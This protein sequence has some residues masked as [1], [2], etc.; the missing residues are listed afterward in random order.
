MNFSRRTGILVAAGLLIISALATVY[1]IF[2][3]KPITQDGT[4]RGYRSYALTHQEESKL[5]VEAQQGH[6][7]SAYRLAQYHLFA[8]LELPKA[9]KYFRV[10]AKC[11]DPNALVG[12]IVLLRKPENDAEIDD[13]LVELKK[14]DAKQGESAAVE[15]ALRRAERKA[16]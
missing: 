4:M 2:R 6:C 9:E 8:T 14:L 13:L 1:A 15:V 16:N 10:A 5:G 7:A 12:L 3:A 11:Q